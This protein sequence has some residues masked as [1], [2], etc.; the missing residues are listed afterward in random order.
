MNW[1]RHVRSRLPRLPTSPEREIEIVE[2]LAA[3]LE[4]TYTRAVAGGASHEE[5]WQQVEDEV[6]DWPALARTLGGI[7]PPR[8]PLPTPRGSAWSLTGISDD[9]RFA[10]RGL[11]A[12]RGL[13]AAAL[14]LALATAAFTVVLAALGAW[15]WRPTVFANPDRLAIVWNTNHAIGQVRDVVSGPTYLDWQ[16]Q[17][18]SFTGLAAFAQT[19]MTIRRDGHADVVAALAVTPE[20]FDVVGVQ[21]AVGRTFRRDDVS[22]AS[23]VV[24][25]SHDAWQSQFGGD[26]SIA[27]RTLKDLGQPH[28]IVGVLPPGFTLLSSPAVVTLLDPRALEQQPRSYYYYW[29]LGRL[30]EGRSLTAAQRELDVVMTRLAQQHA[31]VRGWT[32]TVEPLF[33]TLSE[34]VQPALLTLV[35]IAALVLIIA[36]ANTTNLVLSRAVERRR[37]IAIRSALGATAG[38]V[39]RQWLVEGAMLSMGGTAIGVGLAAIVLGL[40]GSLGTAAVGIAGSAATVEL[41]PPAIDARTIGWVAFLAAGLTMVVG[42]LPFSRVDASGLTSVRPSAA[43]SSIPLTRG[44]QVLLAG[45]SAVATLLLAVTGLLL[46]LIVRLMATP[47]GFDGS[48]VSVMIVGQVHELDAAARARYYAGVLRAVSATPGVTAAALND[49]VPLTNEDDYEGIEIPGRPRDAAGQLPREEWRRVSA[50]YF[51]TMGIPVVRGRLFTEADDERAPSVLIVNESMSRKYWPGADPIGQRIRIT[52]KAYGWSEVIGVVGDVREAGLD[53][54]AKPMLFVPF[55]RDPR[56]V[57]GLFAATAGTSE[58]MLRALRDAVWSVDPARPVFGGRP[59]RRIVSD[60]YAL[61]RVTLWTAAALAGL[62][63][64]LMLG[65]TYAVV[66]LVARS[67]TAEIG[68]RIALGAGPRDIL[69]AVLGRPCAAAVCGVLL[70]VAATLPVAGALQARMTGVP[71]FDASMAGVVVALVGLAVGA[72]CLAP[73]RRAL[74]IDPVTALRAE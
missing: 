67:R 69:L 38:R 49:Y 32:A 3:Q 71:P 29:V 23:G 28:V 17:S 36:I 7:E 6:P 66:S 62:A 20:F 73:A 63:L 50:G 33:T 41:P 40:L 11:A 45:Q 22:Q 43:D 5:A 35:A 2:E 55:H 15:I 25:I 59:M 27:G 16:R 31:G 72:A 39:R 8:S 13:P 44:R 51:A 46:I 61:Q 64:I 56:P 34:P 37:D 47:P 19:E 24:L 52:S 65:G 30:A 14:M 12:W 53:R 1:R 10:A 4:A 60:S 74:R 26:P 42:G 18:R 21:A 58:P 48:R 68:I 9:V 54:P 70:G 57:M